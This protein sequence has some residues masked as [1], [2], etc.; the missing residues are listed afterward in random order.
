MKKQAYKQDM[1]SA[2]AVFPKRRYIMLKQKTFCVEFQKFAIAFIKT[3]IFTQKMMHADSNVY[4]KIVT[5]NG[6][7]SSVNQFLFFLKSLFLFSCQE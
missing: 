5:H 6:Q 7:I 3:M 1:I 2:L 4:F